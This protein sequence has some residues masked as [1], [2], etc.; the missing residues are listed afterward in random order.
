M[1]ANIHVLLVLLVLV[2]VS[3]GVYS[4]GGAPHF[5]KRSKYY[6]ARVWFTADSDFGN[7]HERRSSLLWSR[8]YGMGIFENHVCSCH[9][10]Y[11]M[12]GMVMRDVLVSIAI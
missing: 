3:C 5:Q 6:H 12:F 10:I 11:M 1:N 8:K 4:E 7:D 2:L 9:V